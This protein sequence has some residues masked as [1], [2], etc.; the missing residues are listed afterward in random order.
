MAV[1]N[2]HI[3]KLRQ[4]GQLQVNTPVQQGAGYKDSY[5][6]LLTCRGQLTKINGNRGLNS[7]EVN[8]NAAWEWICRFQTAIDGVTTKKS[9]RWLIDG[10]RFTV[11]NYELI[12]HK[13][14][15]YRFTLLENE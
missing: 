9:I 3:G 2:P 4:S 10:R 1:S 6:T 13:K 7:A 5:A 11:N 12:D 15:Y 14:R 8:I